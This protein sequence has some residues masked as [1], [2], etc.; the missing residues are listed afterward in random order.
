[1]TTDK[2]PLVPEDLLLEL[3]RRFRDASPE[4]NTPDRLVWAAVG[5]REVVQLL[6]LE[7]NEQNETVLV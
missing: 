1:M 2:F 5:R 7:F 4:L 3:E 6:R